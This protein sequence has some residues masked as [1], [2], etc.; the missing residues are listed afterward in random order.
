MS[1]VL[2]GIVEWGVGNFILLS[3]FIRWDSSI[4]SDTPRQRRDYTVN[5]GPC[6]PLLMT[7]QGPLSQ[8][9]PPRPDPSC[10]PWVVTCCQLAL[11][12]G[13]Q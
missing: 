5:E 2:V 4:Q 7:L 3:T 11:N 6:T 1:I 9:P 10:K 8:D 13:P 12:W